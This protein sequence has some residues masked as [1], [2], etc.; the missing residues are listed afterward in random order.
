MT[1][2]AEYDQFMISLEN[3]ISQ[4]PSQKYRI[5]LSEIR[6]TTCPYLKSKIKN[7]YLD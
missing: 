5:L 4:N 2:I 3:K 7:L 6:N 1:S